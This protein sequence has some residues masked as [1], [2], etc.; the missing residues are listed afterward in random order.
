MSQREH[1]I[2]SKRLMKVSFV[3]FYKYPS[4]IYLI[5]SVL[6]VSEYEEDVQNQNHVNQII[7]DVMKGASKY[8]QAILWKIVYFTYFNK[9]YINKLQ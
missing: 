1:Y 5:Y 9:Q 6:G 7:F 8:V 3:T 4:Y 2:A